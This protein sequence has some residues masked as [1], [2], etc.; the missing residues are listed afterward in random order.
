MAFRNS[1]G[2]RD[3]AVTLVVGGMVLLSALQ[4]VVLLECRENGGL[5]KN[6]REGCGDPGDEDC[7][8]SAGG[9]PNPR[10]GVAECRF[11]ALAH[12]VIV[13][14]KLNL[15]VIV[16]DIWDRVGVLAVELA[17]SINIP[18]VVASARAG[19]MGRCGD[20]ASRADARAA[21]RVDCEGSPA[22]QRAPGGWPQVAAAMDRTSTRAPVG[23]LQGDG[24][25][26][27]AWDQKCGGGHG[28]LRRRG[29][30]AGHQHLRASLPV[31]QVSVLESGNRVERSVGA[32]CERLAGKSGA[33]TGLRWS[34]VG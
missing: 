19:G 2:A 34:I 30:C 27:C 26:R 23:E 25:C 8:Q 3:F 7:E 16:E 15:T 18:R 1:A 32:Q 21:K 5:P 6:L 13:S 4:Y 33:L 31:R 11:T 22:H 24:A 10:G 9:S 28:G 14:L 12:V 29:R 17:G 20:Q